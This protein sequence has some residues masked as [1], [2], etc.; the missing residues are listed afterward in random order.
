MKRKFTQ[1]EGT[2]PKKKKHCQNTNKPKI[3][4][5]QCLGELYRGRPRA[6]VQGRDSKSFGS[7]PKTHFAP[8]QQWNLL[9]LRCVDI[10]PVEPFEKTQRVVWDRSDCDSTIIMHPLRDLQWP[11]RNPSQPKCQGSQGTRAN[12]EGGQIYVSQ[13]FRH[14]LDHTSAQSSTAANIH[15]GGFFEYVHHFRFGYINKQKI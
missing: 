12:L 3:T 4:C 7:T 8:H 14:C 13:V 15:L 6:L 11:Y 9:L 5:G 10:Q 1:K 2:S